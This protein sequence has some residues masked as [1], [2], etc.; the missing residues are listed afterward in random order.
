[1]LYTVKSFATCLL[2]ARW[3]S[4]IKK[5]SIPK[6]MTHLRR[7]IF[8]L[9]KNHQYFNQIYEKLATFTL[10]I[11]MNRIEKSNNTYS[12]SM[13]GGVLGGNQKSPIFF[14]YSRQMNLRSN[15]SSLQFM[16][17]HGRPK[18][19]LFVWLKTSLRPMFK[20]ETSYRV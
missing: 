20:K 7:I 5:K 6:S 1:M 8:V 16:N 17:N 9:S 12:C 10:N 2:S 13:G 14:V 19:V 18:L 15:K 3:T 11:H 4:G